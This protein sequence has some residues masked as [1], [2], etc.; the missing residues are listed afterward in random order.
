MERFMVKLTIFRMG[1]E[2][3]LFN[4]KP[5]PRGFFVPKTVIADRPI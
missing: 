2:R 3:P 4:C 1:V 5:M